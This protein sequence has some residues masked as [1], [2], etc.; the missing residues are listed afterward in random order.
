MVYSNYQC[1]FALCFSLCFVLFMAWWPSAWKELSSWLSACSVLLKYRF[2]IISFQSSLVNKVASSCLVFYAA[3]R[4]KTFF[5]VLAWS[6]Y[7][8]LNRE[9]RA[10]KSSSCPFMSAGVF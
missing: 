9:E 5:Y 6:F 8:L 3:F 7:H 4:F 1:S 2:L 10:G